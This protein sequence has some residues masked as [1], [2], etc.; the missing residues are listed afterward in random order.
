[1]NQ[2]QFIKWFIT[3]FLSVFFSVTTLLF[4]RVMD[5][6]GDLFS[7]I[8]LSVAVSFLVIFMLILIKKTIFHG[9]S[10][11]VRA[12][13]IN[14]TV[15]LLVF[16][17]LQF[18]LLNIDRSRSFYILAWAD[19]RNVFV[20]EFEYIMNDVKSLEKLNSEA[21]AARIDEQI[22]KRF[23]RIEGKKVVPTKS[24]EFLVYM[25]NKLAT[26]FRLNNWNLNKY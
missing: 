25:S 13:H 15:H 17:V 9:N 14:L 6:N 2:T 4:L 8:N 23:L 11:L 22:E 10:G 7:Q 21:I 20:S 1:M 3:A 12:M 26:I 5:T 24:G 18:S 19:Q 16:L